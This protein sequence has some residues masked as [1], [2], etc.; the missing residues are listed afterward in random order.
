MRKFI[1]TDVVEL[2][3][4][5]EVGGTVDIS[6]IFDESTPVTDLIRKASLSIIDHLDHTVI[7]DTDAVLKFSERYFKINKSIDFFQDVHSVLY[8]LIN[9]SDILVGV[10]RPTGINIKYSKFEYQAE[11]ESD[12]NHNIIV[13][14]Y[15]TKG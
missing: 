5:R 13:E 9:D 12:I 4:I 2:G 7:T 6:L 10:N 8:K 14:S 15:S 3:H 11:L 1:I